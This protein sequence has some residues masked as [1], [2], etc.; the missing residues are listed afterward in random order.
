MWS[1]LFCYGGLASLF[2]QIL[3]GGQDQASIA[4]ESELLPVCL[5]GLRGW[6]ITK[7]LRFVVGF[8]V[9]LVL[10]DFRVHSPEYV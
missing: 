9:N 7:F 5:L 6:Y 3:R 10:V 2:R 4:T 1:V 8:S